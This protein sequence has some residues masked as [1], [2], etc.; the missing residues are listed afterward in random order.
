YRAA[1][2]GR[3]HHCHPGGA[4]ATWRRTAGLSASPRC[5]GESPR[6]PNPAKQPRACYDRP[7]GVSQEV[8]RAPEPASSER[9]SEQAPEQAQGADTM[10]GWKKNIPI[11]LQAEEQER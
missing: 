8:R 2:P 9:V 7:E 4:P 5:V 6:S 11:C 1:R 10:P 3:H